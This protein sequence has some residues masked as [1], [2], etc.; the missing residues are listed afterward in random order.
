MKIH[1][2]FVCGLFY[3]AFLSM[4]YE[5]QAQS[6]GSL[7]NAPDAR[8]M[9]HVFNPQT[10]IG[11]GF[12]G[13]QTSVQASDTSMGKNFLDPK[14]KLA[15]VPFGQKRNENVPPSFVDTMK[16]KIFEKINSSVLPKKPTVALVR[17]F[18]DENG[19]VKNVMSRGSSG[20]D[21]LDDALVKATYEV[22]SFGQLPSSL[23]K[24]AKTTGVIVEFKF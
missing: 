23:K 19:T 1:S 16:N 11:V 13:G 15:E 4:S 12:G 2:I 7:V 9:G 22:Q 8:P 6:G 5:L 21:K 10:S 14:A 18:M 20:N 24:E 17:V 3:S